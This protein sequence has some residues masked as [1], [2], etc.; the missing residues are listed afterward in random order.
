MENI[1]QKEIVT[2]IIQKVNELTKFQHDNISPDT[3]LASVGVDSLMAVL[4][5][6][7]IEDEYDIEVEP[8]LMFQYKTPN[9]VSKAVVNMLKEQT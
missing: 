1:Q 7:H 4:M 5:C 3:N 2:Y 8:I 9:E 6:G